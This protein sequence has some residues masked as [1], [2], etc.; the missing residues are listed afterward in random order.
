VFSGPTTY[1]LVVAFLKSIEVTKVSTIFGVLFGSL[2]AYISWSATADHVMF[3][4]DTAFASGLSIFIVWFVSLPFLQCKPE[5]N[6]LFSDYPR[7]Y[8]FV[9]RNTITLILTVIFIGICRNLLFFRGSLFDVIKVDHFSRLFKKEWFIYCATGL[10]FGLGIVIGRTQDRAVEVTHFILLSLLKW[11]LPVLCLTLTGFLITLP[12]TGFN[13]IFETDVWSLVG[14]LISGLVLLIP[15]VNGVYI[16]GRQNEAYTAVIDKFISLTLIVAPIFAIICIYILWIRVEEY[17]W[18]VDRYRAAVITILLC[19]YIFGYSVSQLTNRGDVLRGLGEVNIFV[20]FV[21]VDIGV[22]SNT[23]VMNPMKISASSQ[24]SRL[25][26]S[27]VSDTNFDY[28]YLRRSLEK[29]G[30]KVLEELQGRN[31]Y[32]FDIQRQKATLAL[33]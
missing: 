5:R 20:T 15:F 9:W 16:D 26:S 30:G 25:M 21:I 29:S 18:T 31:G 24:F 32:E 10:F 28:S 12:I 3:A 13:T 8:Y 11:L 22:I 4:G 33:S 19:I 17:G 7:L 27:S 1:Q 6:K 2:A 14:V 23:P